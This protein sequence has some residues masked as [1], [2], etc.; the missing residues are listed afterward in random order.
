MTCFN[1]HSR[2]QQV[3]TRYY[4]SVLFL[5]TGSAPNPFPK[6]LQSHVSPLKLLEL[7]R[8]LSVSCIQEMSLSSLDHL[9]NTDDNHPTIQQSGRLD[10]CINALL[11]KPETCEY[12]SM[13]WHV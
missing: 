7:V 10:I 9:L 4:Y 5:S 3:T 12:S 2:A 1:D 8:I 13:V 6:T 11:V